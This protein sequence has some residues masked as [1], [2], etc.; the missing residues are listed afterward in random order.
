MRAADV[1]EGHAFTYHDVP[2]VA[3]RAPEP[4]KD[5]F[6]RDMVKIYTRRLDTSEEGYVIYGPDARVPS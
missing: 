1:P 3:L 2:C 5:R 6:G 4:T